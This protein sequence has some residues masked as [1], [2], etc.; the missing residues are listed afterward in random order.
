MDMPVDPNEPTY[1]LCHQVSYGEMIGCDNPECPIEWF[2]FACVG[3]NTKPKGRWYCPKCGPPPTAEK[4]RKW[5]TALSEESSS[6]GTVWRH[7][8]TNDATTPRGKATPPEIVYAFLAERAFR[9][10][11]WVE[12]GKRWGILISNVKEWAENNNATIIFN[13][14]SDNY[15]ISSNKCVCIICIFISFR[16]GLARGLGQF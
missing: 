7:R 9:S 3:L 5:P 11:W 1:C 4:K 16:L 15:Y 10:K 14:I 12:S 8:R 2:H 6:T 13:D